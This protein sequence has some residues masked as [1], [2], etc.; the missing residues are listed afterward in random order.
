MKTVSFKDWDL[1]DKTV[2]LRVDLNVPV[3][4]GKV[5]ETSRIDRVKP[6]IDALRQA[7]ARIIVM[8]HFGRP[9]G[10]FNPKYSLQFILP[11]LQERWDVQDVDF[12]PVCI[13][14]E[15]QQRAQNLRPGHVLLLENLRFHAG[16]EGNDPAF[17]RA[18]AALGD[19]YINDAFSAAHRAHASTE[20]LAHLLP[21]APGLLMG[22]EIA[23]LEQALGKPQHPVMAFVGGSKISTKLMVLENLVQKVDYLVLGGAMANTFLLAAGHSVGASMAEPDMINQARTISAKAAARNCQ[24]VL[25]LDLTCV[26]KLSPGV[27]AYSHDATALPPH[28][29]AV[30]LGPRSIENVRTLVH[31]AKT[32]VWNGPMGVF[33]MKPFDAGTNALAQAV[34]QATKSGQCISIAGGGDTVSALENANCANDFTYLST[35]GGAFLEWLEGR[36][37]PGVAALSAKQG[38]AA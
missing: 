19:F 35:A 23:A 5:T 7:Q 13:G 10:K 17:A 27:S 6:T 30:D 28:L 14:P 21:A 38:N 37:L 16:E 1:K 32:I 34:A 18:L 26:E 25:P 9:E 20:G 11:V 3:Q 12:S 4:D 2:L 8:A 15:A 22:A 33:E 31:K 24:I 29:R 36:E